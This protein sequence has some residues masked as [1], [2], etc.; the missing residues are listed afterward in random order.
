MELLECVGAAGEAGGGQVGQ[1]V[2]EVVNTRV[3]GLVRV[4]REEGGVVAVRERGERTR[5]GRVGRNGAGGVCRDERDENETGQ[6]RQ[7]E[8]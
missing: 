1:I 4:P 2:V 3:G 5:R 7:A 6:G 8:S